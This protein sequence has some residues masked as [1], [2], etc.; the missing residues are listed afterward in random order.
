M[1]RPLPKKNPLVAKGIKIAVFVFV[2]WSVFALMVMPSME[3]FT[4]AFSRNGAFDTRNFERLYESARVRRLLGNTISMAFMTLLTVSI[5]GMFQVA[6]VEY[7]KICG[8]VWLKLAFLTPLVYESIAIVSGYK[9]LYGSTS[10]ITNTI[11]L[12]FPDIN[13]HWFTGYYA[14]L[15]VHTFA[16]TGGY[17]LF[18][19]SAVQRIDFSM[20]RAAHGLGLGP[21]AT[22]IKV[23]IPCILPTCFAISVLLLLG[24]M[25]SYAAPALLG[26]KEFQMISTM[27]VSLAGM[28][29]LGMAA[30]LALVLATLSILGLLLLKYIQKG[31]V[32]YSLAK[33]K[34]A[35]E[36]VQITNPLINT[37]VHIISYI[38]FVIYMLPVLSVIVFSFAPL[39]NIVSGTLPSSL[40]LENYKSVLSLG[41]HLTPVLNSFMV[42]GMATAMALGFSLLCVHFIHKSKGISGVILEGAVYIPWFVP[43][44]ALALGFIIVYGDHHWFMFNQ[45]LVGEYILLPLVMSI[46]AIP[47]MAHMFKAAYASLDPNLD[48]AGKSM[49]ASDFMIFR[50]VT[51]PIIAPFAILIGALSFQNTLTEFVVTPLLYNINNRTLGVALADATRVEAPSI[52]AISLVYIVL[53][54]VLSV[55]IVGSANYFGIDRHSK[56]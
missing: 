40:T 8:A 23:V 53:I 2:I 55:I 37:I 33:T 45:V 3:V 24:A 7:F 34:T 47:F 46:G 39:P 10:I 32:Y 21:V 56:G 20:V 26:G 14:V 17:I 54:M 52:I 11:R 9:F 36:K 42:G 50:R 4:E 31:G 30:M 6:V 15:I 12:F 48:M 16:M 29:R 44:V 28:G 19:R 5:V 1:Q 27:I 51:L 41:D 25:G 38:L 49:G 13:P 35:N 22:F 18:V 43:G